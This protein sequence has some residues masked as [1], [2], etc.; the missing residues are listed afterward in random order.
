[1][2]KMT[3]IVR[4]SRDGPPL[5]LCS[6]GLNAPELTAQA[7]EA[8]QIFR[9]L[10]STT[11]THG[12]VESSPYNYH[13][14]LSDNV[15]F[16]TVAE[17]SFSKSVAFAFLDEL[18][19]EFMGQFGHRVANESRPYAYM[20]FER[21][22]QKTKARFTDPETRRNLD[23]LG[24]ELKD[25]RSIM[26]SNIQDV[27]NRGEKLSKAAEDS[28]RLVEDSRLYKKSATN[29]NRCLWLRQMAPAGFVL[30]IV[31]GFFYLFYFR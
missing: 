14:C 9:Q 20:N 24:S 25:V 23:K 4:L 6:D 18:Q 10:S 5:D 7:R 29:L 26:S 11:E 22:L 3:M 27:L 1:M 30:A 12:T 17:K 8:N 28:H 2:P 19:K 15:C 21:F 31:G 13:Y 16:M